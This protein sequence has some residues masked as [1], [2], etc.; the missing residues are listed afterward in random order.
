MSRGRNIV[1]SLSYRFI[2]KKACYEGVKFI[3]IGSE[4]NQEVKKWVA[5]G[6][7]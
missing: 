4:I 7:L 1:G 2:N 5:Y 3:R 6:D